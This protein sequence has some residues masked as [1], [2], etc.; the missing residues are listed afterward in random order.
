MEPPKRVELLTYAL[1]G[2]LPVCN[3]AL[4]RHFSCTITFDKGLQ[5]H[6]DDSISLHEWLHAHVTAGSSP[7]PY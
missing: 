4:T 5:P 2:P 6:L 3:L 1:R 7:A